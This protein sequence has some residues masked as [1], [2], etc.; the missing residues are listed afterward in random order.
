MY[1]EKI[2]IYLYVEHALSFTL[3]DYY[4]LLVI[5]SES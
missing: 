3:L 2:H 5:Q 1:R 4:E